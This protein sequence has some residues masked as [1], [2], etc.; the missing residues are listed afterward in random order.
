MYSSF[1]L[2]LISRTIAG[3][4][5][6]V[7]AYEFES[8]TGISNLASKVEWSVFPNPSQG[9]FQIY[10]IVPHGGDFV[11]ME[12]VNMAGEIIL[13]KTLGN[14]D[15]SFDFDLSLQPRGIYFVQ[16]I[17]GIMRSSK[18]IVVQ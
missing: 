17:E 12:V 3:N 10:P 5:I 6:D 8:I 7:G 2:P 14:E 16:K 15:A 11:R 4:G 9:L 1:L 18:I 13:S